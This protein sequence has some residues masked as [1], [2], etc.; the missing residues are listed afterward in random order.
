M[1][2]DGPTDQDLIR[3]IAELLNEQNLAEIEIE[4]EDLRVRVTRSFAQ[5]G[6]QQ[7]MVPAPAPLSA[8]PHAHA[9]AAP[10]TPTKPPVD[11]L[12]SNPGTLTSPMVGTA[13]LAPEPGKPNF[14][15]VGTRVSEGQTILIIEAMKTMNQIP[16]HRSG[17]IARILVEDTQPVEYGQPLAVI[18]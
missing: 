12:A 4:R 18:E 9:S 8:A 14:A 13:Y 3:A 1:P 11:A 10:T 2:K 7:M 15:A 6:V 5:S 16:A 17:V